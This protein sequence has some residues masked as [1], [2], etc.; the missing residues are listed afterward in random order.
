ML[1]SER[2]SYV[3]RWCSDNDV[4]LISDELYHGI[5]YGSP[6]ATAW[7][8]NRDAIVVNSFSKYFAMTGWRLG[9]LLAP[10]SLADAVDRLSGNYTI[11]PPTLSQLAAVAAFDCYPELDTH[12]ARYAENRSLLLKELPGIGLTRLAPAD[13]A[14]YIYADVSDH[15]HD[16]LTWVRQVLGDTGVA[17]AP[18]MDFD[19]RAG[20][21]F[22][23]L[24]FAGEY[25]EIEAAIEVLGRY[26]C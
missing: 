4:R 8:F 15:T 26:L 19:T 2:L 9:W 18:G 24:S 22:A 1:S 13:G 14:F 21:R 10:P 20:G 17:L 6:A 16:S 3:A 7:Q 12:V 25:R 11:C 5:S 23:R